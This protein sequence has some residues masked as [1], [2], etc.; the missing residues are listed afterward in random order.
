MKG[1]IERDTFNTFKVALF[2]CLGL[3]TFLNR[4]YH[5]W[6]QLGFG[7]IKYV[8]RINIFLEIN[9]KNIIFVKPVTLCLLWQNL[10]GKDSTV[11]VLINFVFVLCCYKTGFYVSK[12]LFY[13][14]SYLP[15][16]CDVPN[17]NN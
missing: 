3:S 7:N 10:L 14:D 9:M 13:S 15:D 1:I 17:I 11:F 4:T 12:A 5:I 2:Y 6:K 8:V 16:W